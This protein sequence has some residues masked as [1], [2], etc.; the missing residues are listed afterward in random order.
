MGGISAL[1]PDHQ[2]VRVIRQVEEAAF[3]QAP[4]PGVEELVIE[5]AH[6]VQEEGEHLLADASLAE[7]SVA[8]VAA[9]RPPALAGVIVKRVA[10]AND[11][12]LREVLL[13]PLNPSGLVKIIV[14]HE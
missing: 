6:Q 8:G 13:T 10:L 4:E 12:V 11:V 2:T 14:F 5:G 3:V 7:G 1:H 9:V